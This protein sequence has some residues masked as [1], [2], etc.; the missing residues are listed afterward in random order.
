MKLQIITCKF[1]IIGKNYY[2]RY[3]IECVLSKRHEGH[4]KFKRLK[5][6]EHQFK[7]LQNKHMTSIIKFEVELESKNML[8][9]LLA[10]ALQ[11]S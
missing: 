10:F 4:D 11:S 2:Q 3:W 6:Q 8:G 5:H 1:Q 9:W 7:S